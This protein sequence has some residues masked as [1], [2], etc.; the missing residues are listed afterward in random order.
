MAE[1]ERQRDETA[2]YYR[3]EWRKPGNT[4]L[5]PRPVIME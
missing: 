1:A 4:F 2:E 5:A 3:N